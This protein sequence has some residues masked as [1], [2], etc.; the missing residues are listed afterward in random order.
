MDA[1]EWA[2]QKAG[3]LDAVDL[4]LIKW[5]CLAAGVLLAQLVPKLRKVSPWL[6]VTITAGLA[7]KPLM[8]ALSDDS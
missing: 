5:S 4:V 8:D 7:A 2:E 3:R 1:M 6:L